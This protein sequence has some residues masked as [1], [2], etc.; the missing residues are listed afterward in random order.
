MISFIGGHVYD[1]LGHSRPDER[2][3]T[4]IFV[5]IQAKNPLGLQIPESPQ[6]CIVNK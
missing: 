6:M 4:S 1:V 2:G 5:L 3:G